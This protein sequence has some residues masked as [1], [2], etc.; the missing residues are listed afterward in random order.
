MI[1]KNNFDKSWLL[2]EFGSR[3][4][5]YDNVDSTMTEAKRLLK[6]KELKEGTL[7]LAQKQTGG[8]GRRGREW[9]SKKG[10][11]W[12]SYITLPKLERNIYPIY[13]LMAAVSLNKCLRQHGVNSSIKWPNDIIYNDKKMAGIAIDLV[14]K[15]SDYLIIGIGLNVYNQIIDIATKVSLQNQDI[16]INILF[17]DLIDSIDKHI[18]LLNE[19]HNLIL[20]LWRQNNNV[21]GKEVK[22]IPA[23]GSDFYFAKAYDIS[24]SGSLLI[25]KDKKIKE[26]VAADVSLRLV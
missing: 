12:L 19:D 20:N 26:I 2:E 14:N 15:E 23:D 8:K 1:R 24:K 25:D 3:L 4:F 17:S 18:K 7:L 13:S 22:I 21:L 6:I 5:Y 16:N 10:G 9:V 11:I